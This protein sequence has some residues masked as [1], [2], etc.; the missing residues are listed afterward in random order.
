M[1]APPRQVNPFL[2]HP[3]P[4]VPCFDANVAHAE[5]DDIILNA[6]VVVVALF[7]GVNGFVEIDVMQS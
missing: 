7:N 6:N 2:C 5:D 1:A 4:L 3:V